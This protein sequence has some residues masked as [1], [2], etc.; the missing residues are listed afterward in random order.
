MT[1]EIG[2]FSA[3][4]ERKIGTEPV[5]VRIDKFEDA[6]QMFNETK[7]KIME[8]ERT[9]DEI[10]KVKEKED[11]ELQSWEVEV[12]SMK[13]QIEKIDFNIFSKI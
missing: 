1:E 8:I 10:R 2:R 6:L 9:I 7:K 4:G 13:D 3:T 5:F 12:R 11:K